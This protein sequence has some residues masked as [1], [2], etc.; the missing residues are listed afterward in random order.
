L[1]EDGTVSFSIPRAESG[2]GIT[3]TAAVLIAEEMGIDVSDV[4]VTLAD[5]RPE[6]LFN[7]QTQGSASVIS[8][9]TPVRVAAALAR[10]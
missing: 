4:N 2:Q 5:A 1:N 8:I 6:L 7:Q 9:Y 10:G 3:T